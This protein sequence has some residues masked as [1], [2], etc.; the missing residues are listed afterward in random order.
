M[1]ATQNV[2]KLTTYTI[3]AIII[4]LS[5][6][7]YC[8]VLPF[9]IPETT[10]LLKIRSAVIKTNKGSMYFELYP[11]IA[12][13]HVANFKYL[14]DKGIFTGATFKDFEYIIQ[15]KP[16]RRL[17]YSLPPEFSKRTHL[18]GTLGM[19][20]WED[21]LNPERRSSATQFHI[22]RNNGKHMDTKYTIFGSL[23]KGWKVLDNLKAEDTITEI[24]VYIRQR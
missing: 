17:K 3:L 6:R 13:I 24:I 7:A 20:R 12:P 15:A 21:E 2:L 9:Q 22:L 10:D 19:A 14:T 23:V 8:E 1:K 16:N 18:R 4:L 11:E 5:Q